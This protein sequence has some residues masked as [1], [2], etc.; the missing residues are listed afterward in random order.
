MV[1]SF[2]VS[3][4]PINA[5]NI[6]NSWYE[7]STDFSI[8][9]L[10]PTQGGH[11]LQG[12]THFHPRPV[13]LNWCDL[14]R[15]GPVLRA[16]SYFMDFTGVPSKKRIRSILFLRLYLKHFS[17]RTFKVECS[18]IR[19]SRRTWGLNQRYL[20]HFSCLIRKFGWR[21]GVNEEMEVGYSWLAVWTTK[22]FTCVIPTEPLQWP[23]VLWLWIHLW[24]TR[25]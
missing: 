8:G 14:Q 21:W 22:G 2:S 9:L 16:G 1:A 19:I 23:R 20:L 3:G 18:T 17:I 10:L 15:P 4:V 25:P 5:V 12:H 24:W 13:C 7:P 11:E 6:I